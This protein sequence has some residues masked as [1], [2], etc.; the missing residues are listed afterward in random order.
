MANEYKS[1]YSGQEVDEAV[2]K[3]QKA[4][5]T[6]NLVQ[7]TG[8]SPNNVM[9]QSAV[10]AAIQA[11]KT[12][13]TTVTVGGVS[14]QMWDADSKLNVSQGINNAGKA[15]I[16]GSDGNL[17][18]QTIQT[19]GTSVTV[20]GE[21]Q[22]TWN[23]DTKINVF[24]GEENKGKTF[25]VG[26]DG[27]AILQ[28]VSGGTNLQ[29]S[30]FKTDPNLSNVDI[31]TPDDAN[32]GAVIGFYDEAHLGIVGTA[33]GT[34][35]MMYQENNPSK[36]ANI[37]VG[38]G[39]EKDEVNIVS[40]ANGQTTNL[41]IRP[42]GVYINNSKI[43]SGGG[44]NLK[45]S[46]FVQP[47]SFI[48]NTDLWQPNSESNSAGIGYIDMNVKINFIGLTN[49]S[50][51][52]MYQ[53]AT[54]D[55]N[56]YL[57]QAINLGTGTNHDTLQIMSSTNLGGQ[58]INISPDAATINN[59]NILTENNG[60]LKNQGVGNSGKVLTVGEDGNVTPQDFSG[61]SSGGNVVQTTTISNSAAN[62]YSF[63]NNTSN[64]ILSIKLTLKQIANINEIANLILS[65][66]L[67]TSYENIQL[68]T[69]SEFI[70][71]VSKC[72]VMGS[73]DIYLTGKLYYSNTFIDII[74]I[75]SNSNISI[76]ANGL[77]KDITTNALKAL[78]T[79]NQGSLSTFDCEIKYIG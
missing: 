7:T 26:D 48:P 40:S 6:D 17:S 77:Y 37:A 25:M 31:W 33:A 78:I 41:D 9:S 5:T 73:D 36:M 72:S 57:L 28:S 62:L 76:S 61:G 24:Q 14:Q 34:I 20:N 65:P 55:G 8:A 42:D 46:S 66:E 50:P 47:D 1:I 53:T 56:G 35:S 29:Y 22:A 49:G 70:L 12:S 3:S 63:L 58:T 16:V 71:N 67:T 15:M 19:G 69:N 30:S 79:T 45:Y 10:T 44:V 64:T 23:A 38:G 59:S 2:T 43:S 4:L 52:I 11:I 21:H 32:G 60:L 18:P 54:A 74:F 75:V 39:G 27:N 13:G 51:T 68:A